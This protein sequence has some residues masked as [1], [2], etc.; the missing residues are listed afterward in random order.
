MIYDGMGLSGRCNRIF[1]GLQEFIPCNVPLGI[2]AYPIYLPCLSD[3]V[4]FQQQ[5]YRKKET[6]VL[7]KYNV[8]PIL[9][10][11]LCICISWFYICQS[12]SGWFILAAATP[13]FPVSTSVPGPLPL[14]WNRIYL[15]RNVGIENTAF[16]FNLQFL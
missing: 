11:R 5:K 16:S 4:S 2:F 10:Y 8:F 12:S 7:S 14:P 3:F 9:K 15:T 6:R 13:S 1:Y